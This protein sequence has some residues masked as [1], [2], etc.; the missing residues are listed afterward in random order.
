MPLKKL[1]KPSN[2]QVISI[3]SLSKVYLVFVR[4]VQAHA[5]LSVLLR[6][7]LSSEK[8]CWRLRSRSSNNNSD[9]K[10]DTKLEAS[11]H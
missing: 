5:S 6:G 1:S 8:A 4:M 10:Q 7:Q 3:Y 9:S 2:L 11:Q